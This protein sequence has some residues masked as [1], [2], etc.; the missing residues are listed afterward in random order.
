VVGPRLTKHQ[1][2]RV[3][4]VLVRLR[5]ERFGGSV[6]ALA[7]ELGIAQPSLT[8]ILSG[9]NQPS[10]ATAEKVAELS[11]IPLEEFLDQADPYPARARALGRLRG[12]LSPHVEEVVRAIEFESGVEDQTELDWILYAL[13][14]QRLEG[15]TKRTV[16]DRSA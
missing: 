13:A 15:G 4:D 8:N 12:L 3:L 1:A 7:R 11:G 2:R 14:Q 9:K 5:D 6:T 10:R 16:H